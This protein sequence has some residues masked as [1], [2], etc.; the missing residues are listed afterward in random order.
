MKIM[1]IERLPAK[2]IPQEPEEKVVEPVD[3]PNLRVEMS[4]LATTA[5]RL[6][7]V[8]V[9]RTKLTSMQHAG[10]NLKRVGAVNLANA[11]I[12]FT[13]QVA[14]HAISEMTKAMNR[15][16]DPTLKSRLAHELGYLIDKTLKCSQALKDDSVEKKEEP[17]KTANTFLPGAIVQNNFYANANKAAIQSRLKQLEPTASHEPIKDQDPPQNADGAS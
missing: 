10:I 8:H 12:F 7:L 5:H 13:Q 9:S 3:L 17:K 2:L 4:Q 6:G 15:T 1:D 16:K 14:L 11:G